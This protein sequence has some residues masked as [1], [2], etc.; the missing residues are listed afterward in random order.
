MFDVLDQAKRDF[1]FRHPLRYLLFFRTNA[2][3]SDRAA[4]VEADD[5]YRDGQRSAGAS[6]QAPMK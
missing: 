4:A 1:S 3:L 5:G 2:R 6:M